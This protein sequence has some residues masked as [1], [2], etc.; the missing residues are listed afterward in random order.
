MASNGSP[1]YEDII[2]MIRSWLKFFDQFA[3]HTAFPRSTE[4]R[5]SPFWRII[6]GDRY[7]QGNGGWRNCEKTDYEAYRAIWRRVAIHPSEP[8]LSAAYWYSFIR[9]SNMRRLFATD[10]GFIGL[11]P[12]EMQEGDHVYIL[13][14]GKVPYLLRLVSGTRPRTFELVGDCYLHGIMYGEAAGTDEDFHDVYLE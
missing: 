1:S 14:G 10:R 12:P 7:R 4:G 3:D 13:S 5:E 2:E 9:A 6:I 8:E 11:G